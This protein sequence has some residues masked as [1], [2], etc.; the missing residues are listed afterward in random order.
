MH[1]TQGSLLTYIFLTLQYIIS[2]EGIASGNYCWQDIWVEVL[3]MCNSEE[4]T[5]ELNRA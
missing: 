5:P 1:Q 4:Q 2:M 3:R